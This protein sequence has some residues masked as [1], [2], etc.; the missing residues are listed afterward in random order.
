MDRLDAFTSIGCGRQ[1]GILPT[2]YRNY[3][4]YIALIRGALMS[5]LKGNRYG[6]SANNLGSATL[7]P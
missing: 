5:I 4:R 3:S 1:R 2:A 7:F 6:F